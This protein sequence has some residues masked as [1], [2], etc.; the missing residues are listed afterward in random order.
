ME[1]D[2]G[3]GEIVFAG[4]EIQIW[5][6]LSL[7]TARNDRKRTP[8]TRTG[9]GNAQNPARISLQNDLGGWTKSRDFEDYVN[10]A[11]DRLIEIDHLLKN[12][13]HEL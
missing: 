12:D 10:A 3:G 7:K 9:T 8:R 1:F 2:L 5:L 4:G 6:F 13:G 11:L